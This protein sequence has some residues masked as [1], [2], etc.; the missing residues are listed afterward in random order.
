M[1]HIV[2]DSGRDDTGCGKW[3]YITYAATEGKKVAIVSAYRVCK[4]TK[5][6]DLT[7]SKKQLGIMY[8]DEEVRPYLVEP[9]KQT[10]IDLQYF[11]EKLEA[12]G[13]EALILMDAN[14]AEEQAYQQQTHNIKLVTKKVFHV[15]GTIEVFLQTFM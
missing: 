11:L 1:V 4:Q 13:H 5:H 7:S 15:D 10:L 6:G 12:T 8:E 3:S 9:H 14:Q 2:V